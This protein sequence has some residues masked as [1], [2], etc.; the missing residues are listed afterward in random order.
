MINTSDSSY[1]PLLLDDEQIPWVDGAGRAHQRGQQRVGRKDLRH[2]L[3]CQRPVRCVI[4]VYAY[5]KPQ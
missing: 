2:P 1:L 5:S 4:C 3:L